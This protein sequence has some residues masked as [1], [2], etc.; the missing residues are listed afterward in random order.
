MPRNPPA[1]VIGLIPAAGLAQRLG[2]LPCSK[3]ILPVGFT[4]D[5]AGPRPRVACECLLEHYAAAGIRRA[6]VLL[7]PGKWDIPAYLGGGARFAVDL[8]YLVAE[9]SASVSET[10]DRAYPF[11]RDAQVALGFPDILFDAKDAYAR[12]LADLTDSACDVVLGLF[13]AGVPSTM[14]MVE[15]DGNRV[16]RVLVKPAVS[17]L[18]ETWGI[19][20]WAPAFTEFLHAFLAAPRDADAP[21]LHMGYVI[22]AAI[23]NRLRVRAVRASD[24]P[25]LDI[26][27]PGNL[28]RLTQ[29]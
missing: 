14:D 20:V 21:E 5:A 11:V 4:N 12:L 1:Q 2:R 28:A 29:S 23:E 24:M 22:Q 13:P 3:E 8:A 26:G 19:A 7:R 6:F 17:A 25:F 10:L 15:M 18:A 16:T 27:L 9:N